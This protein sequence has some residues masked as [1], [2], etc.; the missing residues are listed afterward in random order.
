ME[1][2]RNCYGNVDETKKSDLSHSHHL[3]AYRLRLVLPQGG[4]RDTSQHP[5]FVGFNTYI[6][7]KHYQGASCKQSVSDTNLNVPIDGGYQ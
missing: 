2:W 5:P 7:E 1:R 6:S 4:E 3:R